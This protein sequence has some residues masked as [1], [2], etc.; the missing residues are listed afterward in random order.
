MWRMS[1][2]FLCK[3]S[4]AVGL[5][6]ALMGAGVVTA[7]TGA[8]AAT[9]KK[10]PP[11]HKKSKGAGSAST[12]LKALATSVKAEKG[13]TFEVVYTTTS[14]GHKQSVTFAQSPPKYLIKLGTGGSVIYTGKETLYCATT[15][16]CVTISG[17]TSPLESIEDLFS[18][19]TAK[20]FFDEAEAEVA[21]KAAGYSVSF[22]SESFGGLPAE[23]ASVTGGGHSGKYCVA[24]N[25][26]LA[27]AGSS[28]GSITLTSYTASVPATAFTAPKG[29]TVI[30]EPS[31]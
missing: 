26:L 16:E 9:A 1:R 7:V 18:P 12:K 5:S 25:G 10:H 2:R 15:A 14:A 3:L 20:S 21:A 23:C 17:S 11:K 8:A 24:K 31:T 28:E 30:T 22:S 27:Y 19:T 13:A 4:L 29:S 6:S